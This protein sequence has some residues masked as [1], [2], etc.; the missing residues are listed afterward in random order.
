M[1]IYDYRCEDCKESFEVFVRSITH[2]PAEVVCPHC[3]S[4]HIEKQ[5]TAASAVG[6]RASATSAAACAPSG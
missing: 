5:A 4:T 2:T 3:G 1:P 6:A